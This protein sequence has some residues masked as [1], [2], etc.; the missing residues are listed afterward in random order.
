MITK[1]LKEK[2][3]ILLFKL[4][5][6]L[7]KIYIQKDYNFESPPLKLLE[8]MRESK[9]I[10][11][12]GAHRGGESPIYE[13]FGKKVIWVEANPKIFMDLLINIKPYKFQKAINALLTD[14][15]N[16][17]KNFYISNNDAA[18]SSVYKF[19]NLSQGKDSLWKNKKLKMVDEM[20]LVSKT[21]DTVIKESKIDIHNYDHWVIDVQGAELD[22]LKGSK[23]NLK[24][25][26]SLYIEVSKG[27]VY[28]KGSQW[29]E[30][31]NFL[32]VC[33]KEMINKLDN[34][35]TL[36]KTIKQVS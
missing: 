8:K 15:D 7:Q 5:L 31:K 36:R 24:F 17:E 1:Y 23:Q 22:V 21:L 34:P 2:F 33:P 28:N 35:I 32:Q 13:W 3:K 18:S 10:F 16:E 9:G 11:H 12:I 26:N 29:T 6:K 27:D 4:N 20:T 19:G 25:C 14:K 30:V